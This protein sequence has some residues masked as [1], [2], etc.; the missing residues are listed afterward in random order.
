[1]TR[2]EDLV[3]EGP[4]VLVKGIIE[5][6]QNQDIVLASFPTFALSDGDK[7]TLRADRGTDGTLRVTMRGEVF[8]GRGFVKS[9]MAG[10]TDKPKQPTHDVDL[11]IKLGAIAGHHGEAMRGL[12]L[13][14]SRRAGQIRS[15]SLNGKLGRD[16]QLLG[17]MRAYPGGRQVIYLEAN[18]AGALFRF[19]DTYP[20]MYG[21]QMW[22]AMDPPT[23]SQA[24]QD[25]L[26]N[27]R[28]FTIR[29]EA[30]LDRVVAGAAAPPGSERSSGA[31]G[32]G[33][34]FTRMR[35]EFAKSPGRLMIRDG[36]VWGPAIGA[37]I[38][39]LLDYASDSVR[40]RGTFVPAY[41]LNN[42]LARLPVV[43]LFMGGANEGLL[44]ITYEVVGQP[45]TP[46]LRVNP[47]SAVMPGILR[48]MFEFRGADQGTG[49][50]PPLA[51][52]R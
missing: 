30:A 50:V 13:R 35:V 24:P 39:G 22:V 7:A 44:G 1:V 33:V 4:G 11:D 2:I 37:T 26:L 31:L 28:D 40:M 51:P 48:K 46:V 52:S 47:V 19:T 43:G 36:V 34:Q 3:V 25:G 14:M 15:F 29:G 6:D 20:R 42:L 9:A 45:R 38:E 17:D 8:D 23:P 21:G 27:V 49:S 12:E 32:A 18:D 5:L 16:A 10:S 41:A